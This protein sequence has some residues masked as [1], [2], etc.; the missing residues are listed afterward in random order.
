MTPRTRSRVTAGSR[1]FTGIPVEE[2]EPLL[3]SVRAIEQQ[4]RHGETIVHAG[5]RLSFFPIILTGTVQATLPRGNNRQIIERFGAGE[6][7]AEAVVISEQ[8]SIV[9]ME[10]VVH[11]RLL[12]VHRARLRASTEIAAE[13]LQ[14]NLVREMSKKLLHLSERLSLL[15]EPRLRR[16]ILM[17]LDM[18]PASADG[19]IS[20]PFSRRE[21][22]DYVGANAKALLRELRRMQDEG[23]IALER[24]SVRILPPLQHSPKPSREH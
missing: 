1:V 23:V 16:R 9:E 2:R 10:A 11:T 14:A 7:F 21:W 12:L 15:V 20:L 8:E 22:A 6:S 24:T 13:R 5:D 19:R 4:Y 18:L 17:S 3:E